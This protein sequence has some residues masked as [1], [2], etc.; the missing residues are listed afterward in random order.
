MEAIRLDTF[1]KE[2]LNA[3]NKAE[4]QLRK[5]V[6]QCSS[7]HDLLSDGDHVLV[8]LSG[9]KDSWALLYLLKAIQRKA[10]FKFKL[11]AI[12]VDGGLLGLETTELERQCEAIDLSLIHI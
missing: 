3:L 12:T 4:V 1:D 9:G 5:Q 2:S 7:E 6:T 8:G 10:P 11:S